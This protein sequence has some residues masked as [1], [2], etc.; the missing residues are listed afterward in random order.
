MSLDSAEQLDFD[1]LWNYDDPAATERRFRELLPRA[2]Q[3]TDRSWHAQ[4]LTQI[5]RAQGLQRNFADTHATLDWAQ[6][7]FTPKLST[8]RIRYL[9][10]RG[11]VFNSS[12]Q[13]EHTGPLF[14]EAADL[15][16]SEQQ[17]FYAADPLHMLAI[18]APP[19]KGVGAFKKSGRL[20]RPRPL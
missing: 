7:L 12:G 4:L 10:E 14:H 1:A 17:D 11:R 8:A 6:A 5:A 18:V 20:Q 19:G 3:G 15:A 2:E 16:Q 9:L 13:A